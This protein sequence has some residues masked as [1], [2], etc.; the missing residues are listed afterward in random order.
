MSS[1]IQ[2]V[3]VL[4][5]LLQKLYLKVENMKKLQSEDTNT[6]EKLNKEIKL[7]NQKNFELKADNDKLRITNTLLGSSDNKRDTKLKINSLI[8]EIDACIAYMAD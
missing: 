4:E 1:L 8:K 7:L 2:Q 6:I 5:D 3:Q